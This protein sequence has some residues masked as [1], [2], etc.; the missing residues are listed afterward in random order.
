MG[1]NSSSVDNG[2]PVIR[3]SDRIDMRSRDQNSP[4]SESEHPALTSSPKS[5]SVSASRRPSVLGR[6]SVILGLVVHDDKE[7]DDVFPALREASV[8]ENGRKTGSAALAYE[9]SV[10]AS[11]NGNNSAAKPS[12]SMRSSSSITTSKKPLSPRAL[13]EDQKQAVS[14]LVGAR[15]SISISADTIKTSSDLLVPSLSK[16]EEVLSLSP[17]KELPAPPAPKRKLD[18]TYP[19]SPLNLVI[20]SYGNRSTADTIKDIGYNVDA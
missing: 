20:S 13:N 16:H 9:P 12:N 4:S 15:R 18:Y 19:S 7:N 5:K 6:N 11:S 10:S 17:M 3:A 8:S 14:R 1:C 2:A